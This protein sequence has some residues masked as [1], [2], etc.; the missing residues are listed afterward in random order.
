MPGTINITNNIIYNNVGDD[1][2]AAVGF[3]GFGGTLTVSGNRIYSNNTVRKTSRWGGNSLP[4]IGVQWPDGADITIRNNIINSNQVSYEDPE[5][6]DSDEIAIGITPYVTPGPGSEYWGR[7]LANLIISS[8]TM[9]YND[10]GENNNSNIM[11]IKNCNL[12]AGADII[13]TSNDIRDIGQ[14]L[15]IKYISAETPGSNAISISNNTIYSSNYEP[16]GIRDVDADHTINGND[17]RRG[18]IRDGIQIKT[19]HG[20]QITVMDNYI[21]TVQFNCM[22]MEEIDN[23]QVIFSNNIFQNA[24]TYPNGTRY[25]HQSCMKMMADG[26]IGTGS[27][28]TG[29]IFRNSTMAGLQLAKAYDMTIEGNQMYSNGDG[30][31][32]A[33][34][35]R[36]SGLSMTFPRSVVVRNNIIRDN[37]GLGIALSELSYSYMSA[38]FYDNTITSNTEMGIGIGKRFGTGTNL[39]TMTIGDGT[40]EGANVIRNNNDGGIGLYSFG[41][42]FTVKGN[43]IKYNTA[44]DGVGGIGLDD[45]T[46]TGYVENNTIFSNRGIVGGVGLKSGTGALYITG[47]DIF[48]NSNVSTDSGV[49]QPGAIGISGT[50]GDFAGT[51]NISNNNIRNNYGWDAPG[52]IGIGSGYNGDCTIYSNTI[53]RNDSDNE[54]GAYEDVPGGVGVYSPA[55]GSIT[56]ESNVIDSNKVTDNSSVGGIGIRGAAEGTPSPLANITIASNQISRHRIRTVPPT[57]AAGV[58]IKYINF[59]NGAINIR[60]NNKNGVGIFDNINGIQIQDCYWTTVNDDDLGSVI[61]E[62]NIINSHARRAYGPVG[63]S[64]GIR[65]SRLKA[66]ISIR[67]NTIDNT[68]AW[69]HGDWGIELTG[70]APG[71]CGPPSS[72]VTRNVEITGNT[73]RETGQSGIQVECIKDAVGGKSAG[74]LL[75]NNVIASCGQGQEGSPDKLAE[76]V[77]FRWLDNLRVWDNTIRNNWQRGLSLDTCEGIIGSST[78]GH[79]NYIYGNGKSTSLSD[80]YGIGIM[81]STGGIT[82]IG[83]DVYS[84]YEVGVSIKDSG[85]ITL[86]DLNVY[87]NGQGTEAD[88][89]NTKPDAGVRVKTCDNVVIQ[90]SIIRNNNGNGISIADLTTGDTVIISGNT[91]GGSTEALGNELAGITIGVF[92][93][94]TN[95]GTITI[96]GNNTISN[97]HDS[98][99]SVIK[100]DN[101]IIQDNIITSNGIVGGAIEAGGVYNA[102]GI[103]IRDSQIGS[104]TGNTIRWNAF[105]GIAA[106]NAPGTISGNTIKYNGSGGQNCTDA[107]GTM[108]A[109]GGISV[110]YLAAGDSLIVSSS[111][112]IEDNILQS[113]SC[114][115]DTEGDVIYNGVT[116]DCSMGY[117]RVDETVI[118]IDPTGVYLTDNGITT[119]LQPS[120]NSSI[121]SG[122][123][124]VI[125]C[126]NITTIPNPISGGD[127][128]GIAVVGGVTGV[129][130]RNCTIENNQLTTNSYGPGGISMG[131]GLLIGPG[132]EAEVYDNIIRSNGAELVVG[133]QT[134]IADGDTN[135]EWAT[136]PGDTSEPHWFAFRFDT[137]TTIGSMRVYTGDTNIYTWDIYFGDSKMWRPDFNYPDY[138]AYKIVGEAYNPNSGVSVG[139]APGTGKDWQYIN[140]EQVLSQRTLWMCIYGGRVED[141]VYEFQYKDSGGTWVSPLDDLLGACTGLKPGNTGVIMRCAT[142]TVLRNNQIYSNKNNALDIRGCTSTVIKNNE[143]Y[144]QGKNGLVRAM[145]VMDTVD[146]IIH[147]NDFHDNFHGL[148]LQTIAGNVT[149]TSNVFHDSN[150]A[151]NAWAIGVQALMGDLVVSMRNNSIAETGSSRHHGIELEQTRDYH[152]DLTIRDNRMTDGRTCLKMRDLDDAD[153]LIMNNL[154]SGTARL[155]IQMQRNGAEG[156]NTNITIYSNRITN[157]ERTGIRSQENEYSTVKIEKNILRGNAWNPPNSNTQDSIHFKTAE[158]STF[159]ISGNTISNSTAQPNIE[160]DAIAFQEL[161]GAT[162]IIK[163]NSITSHLNGAG[164]M[165]KECTGS[166]VIVSGNDIDYNGTKG[167]EF[168]DNILGSYSSYSVRIVNNNIRNNITGEGIIMMNNFDIDEVF[169][170]SNEVFNNDWGVWL[171]GTENV[172]LEK[173]RIYSND[174]I[175]V[176]FKNCSPI[177]GPADYIFSFQRDACFNGEK[178]Y[179]M[180][181]IFNTGMPYNDTDECSGRGWFA[182]EFM[183]DEPRGNYLRYGT[184]WGIQGQGQPNDPAAA[185]DSDA[186]ITEWRTAQVS[187]THVGSHW[188]EFN[189][190]SAAG[191]TI[192]KIRIYA[193]L[194]ALSWDVYADGGYVNTF[195]AGGSIT[196]AWYEND[197]PDTSASTIR[198]ESMGGADG[199]IYRDLYEFNFQTSAGG[200]TW[201]NL[202]TYDVNN[203]PNGVS[204]SASGCSKEADDEKSGGPGQALDYPATGWDT[205]QWKTHPGDISHATHW[206]A[207]DL[208]SEQNINGVRIHT[209]TSGTPPTHIWNVYVSKRVVTP[210]ELPYGD[211]VVSNWSVGGSTGWQEQTFSAFTGRYIRLETAGRTQ[212]KD[213]FYEFQYTTDGGSSWVSPPTATG[214]GYGKDSG[215]LA[216][217]YARDYSY[218]PV[219]KGGQIRGNDSTQIGQ[220]G[221]NLETYVYGVY[222]GGGVE[223]LSSQEG[224]AVWWEN[225][226]SHGNNTIQCMEGSTIYKM[227]G[228]WT[229]QKTRVTGGNIWIVDRNFASGINCLE[230]G[231][232]GE[233]GS[234]SGVTHVIDNNSFGQQ[235][236]VIGGGRLIFNGDN[237]VGDVNACSGGQIWAI[238]GNTISTGFTWYCSEMSVTQ[239]PV[240]NTLGNIG[241]HPADCCCN[242]TYPS[243]P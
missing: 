222:A 216:C 154:F 192:T 128:W 72:R 45:L 3:R 88:P 163:N 24:G 95:D 158:G 85:N 93:N 211:N 22:R 137:D 237:Y 184:S 121:Y 108:G 9:Y 92:D 187:D 125:D 189:L 195:T 214:Y 238:D 89:P 153:V 178:K 223:S 34:G 230:S 200:S 231:I 202:D 55:G 199:R 228:S 84:N 208:G 168:K 58:G 123:Q 136:H 6:Y 97:N 11:G 179:F 5:Y 185:A 236:S 173:N 99:I 49:E 67:N 146:L 36:D 44:T 140:A 132:V 241:M 155:G 152:L 176:R 138:E 175:E 139:R 71:G 197:I 131:G 190:G 57:N 112:I 79:R 124:T 196:P 151:A 162:V 83:N 229:N 209:G 111:N 104:I 28:I 161:V 103:R 156:T 110:R 18:G 53:T 10:R 106:Y 75:T 134:A 80:R 12:L 133:S 37:N 183:N 26:W 149:I 25:A 69:D 102:S 122:S 94:A 39:G 135:T 171:K 118:Y 7:D 239:Y 198:L 109:D 42:T 2:P 47:N 61:I 13:I 31:H 86:K 114:N 63:Y 157:I 165:F 172:V 169:I 66:D 117:W 35:A 150:V 41:G 174:D 64:A 107:L 225:S 113:V 82:L 233:C 43:E 218:K 96:H 205:T 30:S 91:I 147:S 54:G 33:N 70:Y 38:S 148:G 68:T 62:N 81:D 21:S 141:H 181:D 170:Y 17:I 217:S 182:N 221:S 186:S 8:N 23:S 51:V 232:C 226:S 19:T 56:I 73:I 188:I 119:Y 127:V 160:Y 210:V 145:G 177:I 203:N 16:I 129:V 142:N 207:F 130:I 115:R 59:S 27:R 4:T 201:Y 1:R 220:M 243:C 167:I 213:H 77:R 204:G 65:L 240:C 224:T 90:G 206:I 164:V 143:I 166:S 20:R 76:G 100:T 52:G 191:Q 194:E 74:L 40:A 227:S 14:G 180:A 15:G 234:G 215:P 126:T 242:P 212:I 29:N 101:V 193:R 144:N 32:L 219:I 116:L 98:G 105:S 78:S 48:S 87:S 159:I 50:E 46:G 120:E 235:C 60:N